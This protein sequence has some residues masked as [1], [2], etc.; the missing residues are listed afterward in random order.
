MKKDTH[1]LSKNWQQIRK[2]RS[3]EYV[4]FSYILSLLLLGMMFKEYIFPANHTAI[5][6]DIIIVSLFCIVIYLFGYYLNK[7]AD[8]TLVSSKKTYI[9]FAFYILFTTFLILNNTTFNTSYLKIY[10]FLP[11]ILSSITY[12]QN[13]GLY[14]AT[15]STFNLLTL[16]FIENDFSNFEFDIILIIMMLWVFWLIGGFSDLERKIQDY[17]KINIEKEKNI[18]EERKKSLTIIAKLV[19]KLQNTN[20]KLKESQKL[21]RLNFEETNVGM[22]I[23]NAKGKFIKT[24]KVLSNILGYSKNELENLKLHTLNYNK[25]GYIKKIQNELLNNNITSKVFEIKLWHKNGKPVW[26][27]QNITLA[28]NENDQPLYFLIQMEDITDKKNA[29]KQIQY[30]KEKLEYNHLKTKFFSRISHELKTPL[31][32]IFTATNIL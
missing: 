1:I 32:L 6:R 4:I 10:Y 20:K 29:E 8:I 26:I 12:G 18:A 5:P 28:K 22:A 9:Y 31:N 21:F 23:C 27:K 2:D 24:N 19:N 16:N 13:F 30:Q 17:L 15:F 7:Y 25:N 11:V 14:C 3:K